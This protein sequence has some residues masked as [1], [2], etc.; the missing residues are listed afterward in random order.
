MTLLENVKK[1]KLLYFGHVLRKHVSLD[2]QILLEPC[3]VDVAEVWWM[4]NV[5]TW[6]GLSLEEAIQD[7]SNS[8]KWRRIIHNE[9]N[10]RPEED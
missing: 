1:R 4:N 3:L 7:T 9:V 6:K 8:Q 10:S 2:K 5:K